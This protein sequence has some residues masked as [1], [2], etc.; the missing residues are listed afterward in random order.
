[1]IGGTLPSDSFIDQKGFELQTLDD[2]VTNILALT[3]PDTSVATVKT[4]TI[5]RETDGTNRAMYED[6]GLFYR[7]GGGATLQGSVANPITAVESDA[8]WATTLNTTGNSFRLRATGVAATTINWKT[9]VV[10]RIAS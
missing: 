4:R 10:I 2:T 7:E 3:M 5:A 6:T 1:L 9:D 8:A